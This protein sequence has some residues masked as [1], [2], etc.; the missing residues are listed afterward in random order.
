MST[1]EYEV[2]VKT[3]DK[4][5]HLS[6][7]FVDFFIQL[8]GD[9]KDTEW[10]ELK[11]PT[12]EAILHGSR[13][14]P[15][16][17]GKWVIKT[18]DVG[19][20]D[21]FKLK[22]TKECKE[23]FCELVTISQSNATDTNEAWSRVYPVYSIISTE[24]AVFSHISRIPQ[25]EGETKLVRGS[26]L[27]KVKEIIRWEKKDEVAAKGQLR[28][29]SAG[30]NYFDLPLDL[31]KSHIRLIDFAEFGL[32]GFVPTGIKKLFAFLTKV[33]ELSDYHKIHKF[34][35]KNGAQQTNHFL[36]GWD[37]DQ[38]MGQQM[39]TSAAS[40]M[41]KECKEIP[42]HFKVTDEDVKE[43]LGG[44]TIDSQIAAGKLFIS[45]FSSYYSEDKELIYTK[46]ENGDPCKV[47]PATCL[48]H[49]NPTLGFV[50]IAIQLKPNDRDYLFTSDGSLKWL[51]AKM[52]YRNAS[53]SIYE[54]IIH[55]SM[56]HATIEAFQVGIFRNLS[57]AHPMYKLLRPHVRT[58]AA[59]GALAR[60]TLIPSSSLMASGVSVD[61]TSMI[62]E[63]FK[64][65]NIE[66]LNMPK[67]F[68]RNGVHP[69]KIPNFYYGQYTLKIWKIVE[70][71][72]TDFVNLYY[73][74]DQDVLDDVEIQNFA[75][76]MAH[77]A[78]GWE[79]GN[80][81]GM[82]EKI[83][84]KQKLIEIFTIVI[85]TSSAQ[86]SAVNFAQYETYK[87]APN[88]PTIMRMDCPKNTEEVDLQ[89]VLDSLPSIRQAAFGVGFVY[90]L[91]RY[92]R[93]EVY[94]NDES[95]PEED[96]HGE[97][98]FYGEEENKLIDKYQEQLKK[99]DKE[100]ELMNSKITVEYLYMEPSRVPKS[101]AI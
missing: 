44:E 60:K 80:F 98:W 101:I 72:V 35:D 22:K 65:Y 71:H 19:I 39:L 76:E 84:T 41:F 7:T 43:L 1:T 91:S 23:W 75:H 38:G 96:R 49:V 50:P 31:Q 47:A 64:T 54:W 92:S 45:D 46:L 29:I 16:K 87:F 93:V 85:A 21:Y 61:A 27:D 4:H 89:R 55:Y 77:E 12:M 2:I 67:V 58:V 62:L 90:T 5:P 20:P 33:D 78:F 57:Q 15:G 40:F 69:D 48:F 59:M 63:Y 52:Y 8:H 28:Y 3:S 73:N 34:L 25:N 9:N 53:F 79:D 18:Q 86:H 94:L 74:S 66:N 51:L 97:V 99:L 14:K 17:E 26:Q 70:D 37:T 68:E 24:F 6:P 100:I 11:T 36:V 88:C 42:D 13:F 83:E 10:V 30:D 81:R 32:E 95:R 82:P 56:T